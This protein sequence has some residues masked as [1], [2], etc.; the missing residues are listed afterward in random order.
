MTPSQFITKWTDRGFGERQAAQTW[1]LDLLRLVG[2]PDP[3]EYNDRDNLT[4][5]KPVPGGFADA[6]LARHFGWEFKGHEA[7]L[8]D[9]FNQLLRYQVYLRTPPLLIVSSFQLIR[10]QTNFPGKETVVHEIPISELDRPAHLDKLRNIFFDPA[11]FEPQRTLE[12]VTRETALLFRDIVTDMEEHSGD[13]ERLARYLNQIVFCLYAQDTGLLPKDI[14]TEITRAHY[15]NPHYFNLAVRDL[16]AKMSDGGLFGKDVI[17]RFNGDLFDQSDTVELS[18]VALFRLVQAVDKNWRD[19]EPS[20]FGT[21]FEGALD[22]AK[23][24]QLGAHYTSA[25]DIM[26]VVEPVLMKPLRREWRETRQRA[27]NLIAAGNPDAARVAL[28]SFRSRLSGATI[29]DPACG[30][31]NFLYIALRSLLDL[32]KQVI[33]H[34]ANLE[35][36]NLTPTV[37]PRQMYGLEIDPYAAQIARTALWIG[38]IQW[39]QS[40]GFPYTQVPILTSLDTIRQTDA[41]LDITDPDNPREPEWPAAEFIV[42]NPPF[43]GSQLIRGQLKDSYTE[44]L[45]QLYSDRIPSYSD[46]CCY[47][48]EKSRHMLA[49]GDTE[50]VGLLATQG[51]RGGA[52]RRV[53][54][55]IK[56][57]GDI[58]MAHSDREWVLD[59]AAVHVSIVC[60]DDG[61]QTEKQLDG[62]SVP[63]INANLMSGADLTLAQ[64]LRENAGVS[65][66]GDMKKGKFEITADIASEMLSEN[67]NPN[68][69]PNSDVV[70]PWV[71]ALDITRRARDMW[72]IDFD[73]NMS[74]Y[75]AAQY[76]LPFE[77]VKEH[78]KPVR[79]KVRNPLERRRWWVHG[80]TAPDFR[81][82]VKS[83]DRYIATPRVSKHR[84]FVYMSS[85][86]LPDG[87]IVAIA[88]DD[89]YTLGVL[90]SR[91]HEL[92]ARAMGTQLRE[93][94]S[95][96]RYTP[97]TCFETF[98]FPRPTSK[99]RKAIASVAHELNQLRENWRAADPK[100][101]LTNLYNSNPTWLQNAHADLDKAV[102]D[103]YDWPDDLSDHHILE[104]LL[105]LNLQRH[106]EE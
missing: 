95:G 79:E 33:D 18:G 24:S 17:A 57:S 20:I 84:L 91:I 103:A 6:Y 90:H 69:R 43:L 58:F 26:L 22:A 106:S 5:E 85:K 50:R 92:W 31:G 23:R 10:I 66:I 97:T 13:R 99:Q 52:S 73:M 68:G 38:Y 59:G 64:K 21:L 72:I 28:D 94:E 7:D 105:A 104:N 45:F 88:R 46:Y 82:A 54:E 15:R 70:R 75:E 53:L 89:D 102:A 86:V 9:A 35:L 1:F 47:W 25:N 34:A 11:A 41:I 87:A 74:E 61:I 39:H 27:D 71:N 8:P 81:H 16:F 2:H 48:F 80:R 55:R 49:I 19:I 37:S 3:I 65:F 14:F 101:T 63:N 76:E 100:R 78:V 4:F 42:G 32:E 40:N 98:P 62:E 67:G 12:E 96:F 60:F 83:L 29:L 56:E 77:Y 44:P 51:I 30:S 93:A 36:G